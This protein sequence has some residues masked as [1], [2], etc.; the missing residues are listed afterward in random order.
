MT[1]TCLGWLAAA[2]I[3]VAAG[4]AGA[5]TVANPSFDDP[6]VTMGPDGVGVWFAFNG[7]GTA[8]ASL[9]T[10]EPHTSA[11]HLNLQILNANNNFAGVFQDVLG[12][13]PGQTVTYSAWNKATTSP[14]GLAA[15]LRIEWR[16]P[17]NTAEVSRTGNMVPT[18]STDYT[19]YSFDAVV[20][21]GAA[22][23]RL[24]YA[25]Q[26]FGPEPGDTGTVFVDD[27]SLTVVPEPGCAALG[28]IA[29]MALAGLRRRLA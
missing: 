4:G 12:L 27:V 21:A 24:V 20:P 9:A 6:L 14:V 26:T 29:L 3:L 13:T 5:Q 2:S 10:T 7:G 15:E 16:N 22:G 18:L 17:G 11:S 23:A 1:R 25:I 19:K 8:S 28:G